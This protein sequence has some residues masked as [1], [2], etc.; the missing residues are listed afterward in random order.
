M[1]V[2]SWAASSAAAG[3]AETAAKLYRNVLEWSKRPRRHGPRES[4]F[5][6]L[7]EDPAAAASAAL[8][9]LGDAR[10]LTAAV[11]APA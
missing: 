8:A 2:S 11:A 5:V 7:A 1:R 9:D 4:L 10:A 6:A 3:E